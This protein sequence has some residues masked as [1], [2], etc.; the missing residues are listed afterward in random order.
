LGGVVGE[1]EPS[2]NEIMILLNGIPGWELQDWS[3]KDLSPNSATYWSY[4]MGQ[5]TG[6]QP[7]FL[8][9]SKIGWPRL[10]L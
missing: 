5:V 1:M 4:N 6:F 10:I 2:T 3:W 7:W 9:S 8:S